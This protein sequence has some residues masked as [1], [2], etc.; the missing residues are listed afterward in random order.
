MRM[1]RFERR[2]DKLLPVNAFLRR[3]AIYV[4]AALVLIFVSLV[5][6]VLGYRYLEG[7]AWID[8]FLNACM[9]MGG[10]GPVGEMHR[11][12]GKIFAG[13][14]ALYCGMVLLISFGIMM[15]PVCHR[16]L[17]RFHLDIDEDAH[18]KARK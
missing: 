8:S 4:L 6:G 16:F 10:M 5:G 2:L 18:R 17:H 14:Y 7:M 3:V 13:F 9:I 15:A 1:A 11:N 12:A